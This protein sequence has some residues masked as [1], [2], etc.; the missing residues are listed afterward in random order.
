MTTTLVVLAVAFV[1]LALV[2][3][4]RR[5]SA[6]DAARSAACRAAFESTYASFEPRPSYSEGIGYGFPAFDVT[7]A[8]KQQRDAAGELG[9][10]RRFGE[11]I[12]AI[13]GDRGPRGNRFRWEM[14]THFGYAGEIEEY[15]RAA[16]ASLARE[17]DR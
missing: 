9:L 11:S 5:A 8:S 1:A 12:Q 14:A 2:R 4:W 7:F 16:Q 3:A 13:C 15:L 10:N 6:R 17:P